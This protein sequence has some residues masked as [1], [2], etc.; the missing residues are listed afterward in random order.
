MKVRHGFVSNSSSSSFCVLTTKEDYE[1]ALDRVRK[2]YSKD[3]A[4][5]VEEIF[6]RGK[7]FSFKGASGIA[8]VRTVFSESYYECAYEVVGDD[9][10]K[11]EELG[12]QAYDASDYFR[13]EIQK[14]GGVNIKQ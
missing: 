5:I 2:K 8:I 7:D 11:V 10:A 4:E 6:G 1:I 3:A 12:E 13:D 9:E 14:L